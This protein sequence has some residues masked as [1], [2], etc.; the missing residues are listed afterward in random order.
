M[1]L[2]DKKKYQ[3]LLE[4]SHKVRDTLDL[5]EIMD[6]LLDTVKKVADYDAAGI[7]I[8]NQDFTRG[9]NEQPQ[10]MI[11]GIS[12]RGYDNK[13]EEDDAM[14]MFGKGIVGHV[15]FTGESLVV[16]DVHQDSRYVEGRKRTQSEIAVPIVRNDRTIGALNLESDYPCTYDES[17]LEVLQFYADSAAISIEK[18]MLHRQ[19]LEKELIDKQLQM[20]RDAQSRLFP[21]EAPHMRGYD[22]AGICLPTEQIGGDYYD[23]IKLPNSRLGVAVADVSG[24]GIASALMMTAFRGLL[25]MHTRGRIGPAK[26]AECINRLLPDFSSNFDF[27]TL[28]YVVL[29]SESEEFNYI[30]CGQQ[31]PFIIHSDGSVEKMRVHGPVLGIIENAHY[32]TDMQSILPGEILVMYTDGVVDLT[33]KDRIEFG[34]DR[35]NSAIQKGRNQPAAELIQCVLQA[36]WEFSGSQSFEDD[37]TLVIIKRTA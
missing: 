31:P 13:P 3:L 15:I 19:I 37:F 36:A 9:K 28:L 30:C 2:T 29:S 34:F 33:N 22:I 20:A 12:R 1:I 17:D 4:I 16:P 14:L 21:P 5:D 25:R 10:I 35:L 32:S 23:Y 6:H 24:N 27:V 11:A 18:A 8:L 7:F 26:T